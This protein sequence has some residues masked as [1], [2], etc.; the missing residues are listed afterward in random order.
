MN[1]DKVVNLNKSKISK[2]LSN[3]INELLD[4]IYDEA[5][6][7][8]F[9]TIDFSIKVIQEDNKIFI[10]QPCMAVKEKEKMSTSILHGVYHGYFKISEMNKDM[11]IK[12]N[13]DHKEI[14]NDLCNSIVEY[15][16][17]IKE[18]VLNLDK[19]ND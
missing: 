8:D 5:K 4:Y 6:I 9:S 15:I 14:A 1:E 17:K 19:K 16:K 2:E 3:K 12:N 10:L 7:G 13:K 11:D 18:I